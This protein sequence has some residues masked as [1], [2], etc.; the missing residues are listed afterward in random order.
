MDYGTRL[1]I[2]RVIR[3][4]HQ[5]DVEKAA[6]LPRTRLS[7]I[8]SGLML[9]SPRMDLA[10]RQALGWT[11]EVDAALDALE[12]AASVPEPAS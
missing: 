8:E 11:A 3:G 6:G 9:P 1:K 7:Y 10:V 2:L 4:V 5:E 12:R